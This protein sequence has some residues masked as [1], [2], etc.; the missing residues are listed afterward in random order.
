MSSPPEIAAETHFHA[1]HG[2][3]NTLVF[4]NADEELRLLLLS[5]VWLLSGGAMQPE[6]TYSCILKVTD[7]VWESQKRTNTNRQN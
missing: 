2:T 4:L 7:Q 5:L 1:Q 3:K 6:N